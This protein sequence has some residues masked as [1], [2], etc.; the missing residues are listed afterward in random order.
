MLSCYHMNALMTMTTIRLS[1]SRLATLKSR[2]AREGKSLNRLFLEM[3]EDFM[4]RPAPKRG[5][6]K[7]DPLWEI[8]K[9]PF[10]SG[11]GD[12]AENHDDYL[13]GKHSRFAR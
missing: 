1:R 11:L 4:R 6:P 8:G 3:V 12:L 13:Y 10:D 7:D 2:A 9:H 5:I